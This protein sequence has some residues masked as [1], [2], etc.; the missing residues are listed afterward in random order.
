MNYLTDPP[1]LPA[2]GGITSGSCAVGSTQLKAGNS[3]IN[4]ELL[5]AHVKN[6]NNCGFLAAKAY[7][8]RYN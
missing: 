3:R 7:Y 5:L 2:R 4:T 6:R 8:F 1:D